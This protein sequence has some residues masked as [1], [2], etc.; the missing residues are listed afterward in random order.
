MI[1]D[2]PTISD[3]FFKGTAIRT[4]LN[5]R[6]Q[7]APMLEIYSQH[8]SGYRILTLQMLK[9]ATSTLTVLYTLRR[10]QKIIILLGLIHPDN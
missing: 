9:T 3:I 2:I 1:T 5:G 4:I 6:S 10:M 8:S 7:K